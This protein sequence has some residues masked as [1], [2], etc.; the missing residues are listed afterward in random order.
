MLPE[1]APAEQPPDTPLYP[2]DPVPK[3]P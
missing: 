1:C 3:R 2:T